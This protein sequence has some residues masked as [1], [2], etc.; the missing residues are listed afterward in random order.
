MTRTLFDLVAEPTEEERMF[1]TL[2]ALDNRN[3]LLQAA[4]WEVLSLPGMAAGARLGVHLRTDSLLA[5][6]PGTDTDVR[7]SL[8]KPE[9]R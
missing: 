7:V 4:R 1:L 2:T 6:Y 3:A 5:P 9:G 8:L